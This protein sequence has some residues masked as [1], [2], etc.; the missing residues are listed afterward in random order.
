MYWNLRDQNSEIFNLE[1]FV[2]GK[3][4]II[5]QYLWSDQK[6]LLPKELMSVKKDSIKRDRSRMW[7]IWN[8]RVI[9]NMKIKTMNDNFNLISAESTMHPELF[10]IMIIFRKNIKTDC[11][12]I[13]VI[14]SGR[15]FFY[16]E[17]IYRLSFHHNRKPIHLLNLNNQC[18]FSILDNW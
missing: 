18:I 9:K 11:I 3:Q 5:C 1:F 16:E 13:V 10:L 4:M 8:S 2:W 12:R 15:I 7:E 14:T 17:R 6:H